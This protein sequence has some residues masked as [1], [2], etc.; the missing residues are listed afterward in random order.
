MATGSGVDA[1]VVTAGS[2]RLDVRCWRVDYDGLLA[3]DW[4]DWLVVEG[5]SVERVSCDTF[6]PLTARLYFAAEPAFLV[7]LE[8]AGGWSRVRLRLEVRVVSLEGAGSSGWFGLGVLAPVAPVVLADQV[9]PVFSVDCHDLVHG[10]ATPTGQ[11]LSVPAGTAL[12]SAID[13]FFAGVSRFRPVPIRRAAVLSDLAT[14]TLTSRQWLLDDSTTW[15][16]VIDQLLESAGWLPPFT[17]EYGL[18][19][20][21]PY[22]SPGA[23]A[24][25]LVLTDDSESSVVGLGAKLS[26]ETYGVPNQFVF[27]SSNVGAGV[28]SPVEGAGVVYRTNQS[29]GDSSVNARGW[30]LV[31]VF[32]VDAADQ[33]ALEAYADRVF[34]ELVSP[35]RSLCVSVAPQPLPWHRGTVDVSLAGLGIEAER[36][37][38]RSWVLPLDGRDA[39]LVLDSVA[40]LT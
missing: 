38:V 28:V 5:C 1:G 29:V 34:V 12:G 40:G 6:D 33:A 21:R 24:A 32:E 22:R 13:G 23:G 27:Y 3:A 36:F 11:S 16:G 31:A 35:A 10:L 18:L 20:S 8:A 17:D 4:S 39:S 19:S 37:L 2:F 14:P 30:D 7:A 9:P 26:V 15:L 25:D